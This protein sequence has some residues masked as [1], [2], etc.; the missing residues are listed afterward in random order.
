MEWIEAT[1]ESLLE[2]MGT[3]LSPVDARELS[4]ELAEYFVAVSRSGLAPGVDGWCEDDAAFMAPWGFELEA[5]RTPVLLLH[6]RQDRFVPFGHGEWL[7]AHIPG[8]QAQLSD[9]DGHVTLTA[10]HLAEVHTW[11]L[12][13]AG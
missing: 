5:I 3:L 10:R 6:G 7:A 2:Q 4:G 13:H 8:V 9:D 1:P 11:L 12:E